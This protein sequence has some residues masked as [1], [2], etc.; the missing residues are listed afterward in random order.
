MPTYQVTLRAVREPSI[1][2]YASNANFLAADTFAK[3]E[4]VEKLAKS[5]SLA[6]SDSAEP[7]AVDEEQVAIAKGRL[8]R[9]HLYY[10]LLSSL[11]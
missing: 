4:L 3:C 5:W 10:L 2:T 11:S 7:S 6:P 1:N 8:S 9:C